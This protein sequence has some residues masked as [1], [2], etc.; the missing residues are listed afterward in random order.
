MIR[1][2]KLNGISALYGLHFAIQIELMA[3]PYRLA[4]VAG[5]DL[6]QMNR[7]FGW[8][9][10]VI[11]LAASFLMYYLTNR[12][13]ES[14]GARFWTAVLWLPYAVMFM[15]GISRLF[16]ITDRADSPPPVLGLL[17]IAAALL[18]PLYILFLNFMTY[19]RR[20]T[21]AKRRIINAC[22]KIKSA[23]PRADNNKDQG[24]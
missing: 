17:V 22:D 4:R 21:N 20:E 18:Y 8:A 11:L 13:L 15:Y 23:N 6:A 2:L 9:M 5:V 16:P 7:I 1:F 10:I 12:L 24:R 19:I 3:E 14:G